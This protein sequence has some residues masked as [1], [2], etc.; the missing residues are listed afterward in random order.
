ADLLRRLRDFVLRVAHRALRARREERALLPCGL[1]ALRRLLDALLHRALRASLI[2]IWRSRPRLCFQRALLTGELHHLLNRLIELAA[3]L[4]LPLSHLVGARIPHGRRG[5]IHLA[6]GV[7]RLLRSI[8]AGLARRRGALARF[9]RGA[10][11][12]GLRLP[13]VLARLFGV[14]RT[15]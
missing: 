6:G 2:G 7:A 3:E 10:A 15:D 12:S 11:H 13:G 9:A 14:R 1:Q 5:S 8:R 4:L